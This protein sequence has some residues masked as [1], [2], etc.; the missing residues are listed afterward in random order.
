MKVLVGPGEY[1]P[2]ASPETVEDACAHAWLQWTRVRPKE[3]RTWAWLVIVASREALRL[4]QRER[5]DAERT[6]ELAAA[7]RVED[8][9]LDPEPPVALRDALARLRPTRSWRC[10]A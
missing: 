6:V 2:P 1:D 4:H 10:C 3:P 8:R 9:R 7:D 5:A